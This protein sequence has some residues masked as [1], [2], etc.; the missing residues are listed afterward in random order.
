VVNPRTLG[1]TASEIFLR[2]D[3]PSRGLVGLGA[4]TAR[5]LGADYWAEIPKIKRPF[6]PDHIT[7][8]SAGW[9]EFGVIDQVH[10]LTLQRAHRG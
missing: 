9:H 6:R 1:R 7:D 5:L 10:G 2:P 3:L 8:R 4:V